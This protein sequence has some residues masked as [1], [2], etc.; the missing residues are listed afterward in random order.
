MGAGLLL[1]PGAAADELSDAVGKPELDAAAQSYLEGYLDV[2][3]IEGKDW[4]TGSAAILRAEGEAFPGMVRSALRGGAALLAV[5]LLYG[6]SRGMGEGL[7]E[8]GLCPERLAACGAVCAV[9]VGDVTA[10]MGLGEA[11]LE[12][13]DAFSKLLLPTVTAACAATG[14]AA[15]AAARQ[16]A[17]LTFLSLLLTLTRSLIL[18]LIYGCIAACVAS[19]ALG[20]DGLKRVAGVLRWAAVTA[21]SLLLTGFVLS[22]SVTAAVG[23]SADAM[24]R[25]TAKAALSGMVPV[26]GGILSDA[27]ETVAAGAGMLKGTVGVVGLLTVLAICAGP[28]LQLGVHYLV[29]KTVAALTATVEGGAVAELIDAMAGAFALILAMTAGGGMMLYVALITSIHAVGG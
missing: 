4:S 27:A 25:K 29:Y 3:E 8:T 15:S 12:R 6:L 11:T 20:N 17:V 1:A 7:R 9:S 21:L 18:P 28:F 23:G 2:S 13:M 5:A 22:L 10:L 26:V 19:A 24:T 14:Q 16:G